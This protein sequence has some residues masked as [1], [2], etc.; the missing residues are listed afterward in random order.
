MTPSQ[1]RLVFGLFVVFGAGVAANAM[2]LQ[3]GPSIT[4]AS[5]VHSA[6]NTGG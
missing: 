5:A 2:L 3:S 4:A 1:V 6:A